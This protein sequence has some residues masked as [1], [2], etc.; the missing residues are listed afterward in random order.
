MKALFHVHTNFSQDG[1]ISPKSLAE[2]AQ[3]NQID[4]LV[5]TDHNEIK[6]AQETQRIA[7]VPVIVGEEIQTK[8]GGEIIGLFL[9]KCIP[10][11][12]SVF[13]AIKEIRQ[14]N[15]I[16]YLPHPFDK[17][18]TKQ[19]SNTIL[20]MIAPQVDIVEVFNSRN[21]ANKANIDALKYAL[22]YNKIQCVGAD[23]HSLIE[24]KSSFV[25][26]NSEINSPITMLDTLR[27][28][29]LHPQ[30][31]PLRVHLLSKILSLSRKFS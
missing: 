4:L 20:E 9:Q 1:S 6:G 22:K 25:I 2:F 11:D 18:R 30:R 28:S 5:I 15:G 17:I 29:Q 16:V 3:K 7:S 8:E 14:Q 19:F 26:F 27:K 12:I 21:I 31:S 13:G 10:R 23:A 24:L